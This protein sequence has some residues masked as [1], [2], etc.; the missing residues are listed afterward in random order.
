MVVVVEVGVGEMGWDGGTLNQNQ[1]S[2]PIQG[3]RSKPKLK[4]WSVYRSPRAAPFLSF[5]YPLL[6]F[7]FSYLFLQDS[8]EPNP[9]KGRNRSQKKRKIQDRGEGNF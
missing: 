9:Q 2:N 5:V 1:K 8:P 3:P 4:G 7:T 6:S